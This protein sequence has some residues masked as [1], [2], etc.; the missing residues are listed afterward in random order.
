MSGIEK[1]KNNLPHMPF[2][3]TRTLRAIRARN[4]SAPIRAFLKGNNG[5]GR[6]LWGLS[7]TLSQPVCWHYLKV[8]HKNETRINIVGHQSYIRH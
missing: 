1:H 4:R 3:R 2:D 8:K 5:L 6:R 7:I